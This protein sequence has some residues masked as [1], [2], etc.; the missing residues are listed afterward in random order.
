MAD[1]NLKPVGLHLIA[2]GAEQFVTATQAAGKAEAELVAQTKATA[3]ATVEL[4]TISQKEYNT[5]LQ[6]GMSADYL[7]ANFKLE[8]AE[9]VANTQAVTQNTTALN[10]NETATRSETTAT[11]SQG[12]A[13]RAGREIMGLMIAEMALMQLT[14]G[15]T[16]KSMQ[17]LSK[18]LELGLN[19]T[20]LAFMVTGNIAIAALAGIAAGIFGVAQMAMQADPDIVALNKDLESLGKKDD[21]IAGLMKLT[22]ATKEQAQAALD[23]AKTSP[24]AADS[25]KKLTD[26]AEIGTG[27]LNIIGEGFSL[28]LGKIQ[29]STKGWGDNASAAFIAVASYLATGDSTKYATQF[30]ELHTQAMQRAKDATIALAEAD[31]VETQAKLDM[32]A[33]D[34]QASDLQKT[35]GDDYTAIAKMQIDDTDKI[36]KANRT[37]NETIARDAR[38]LQDTLSQISFSRVQAEENNL[39]AIAQANQSM[40]DSIMNAARSLQN[41]LSDIEQGLR[42]KQN[43]EARKYADALKTINQS[44]EKDRQDLNTKI[45]DAEKKKLDDLAALD[46]STGDK[47]RK[48]K[49]ENEKNEI[50]LAAMHE[51]GV[52]QSR[53]TDT[54]NAAQKTFDQQMTLE[55]QKLEKL[56]SD[57]EYQKTVEE[58]T[59]SEQIARAQR[60]Y[61]QQVEDAKRRDQEQLANLA[62]RMRQEEEALNQQAANARRRY[63]E[64]VTDLRAALLQEVQDTIAAEKAKA[65]AI[66][67]EI[68]ARMM[69]LMLIM[70]TIGAEQAEIAWQKSMAISGQSGGGGGGG[71]SGFGAAQG[72]DAIVSSPMTIQVAEGYKPER[73]TVTPLSGGTSSNTRT[74]NITVNIQS[75]NPDEVWSIFQRRLQQ[76]VFRP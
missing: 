17:E 35:I 47:L 70:Q 51:R 3:T 40:N 9:V 58:R 39:Q 19:V 69:N 44:I 31:K 45:I 72:M 25:L 66:A 11:I 28:L 64:Q 68:K 74:N 59:A 29:G 53:A 13:R 20:L 49:T 5:M 15:Q 23:F 2:E 67:E 33:A 55:N 21:A 30:L 7:K 75:N 76:E 4:E 6:M 41:S 24:E 32:A 10:T 57:A 71:S 62:I 43:D 50:E 65:L 46:Y 52:I 1:S 26:Q 18:T 54:E 8:T 34:S 16:D 38:S 12:E 42:D 60:T 56:K 37:M 22:G 61:Q 27:A 48:A 73:V 63:D 36:A 14:A